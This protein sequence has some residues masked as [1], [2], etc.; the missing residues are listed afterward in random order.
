MFSLSRFLTIA[1]VVG[2]VASSANGAIL[3]QNGSSESTGA[4]RG[5]GLFQVSNWTN[6]SG[7]AIQASSAAAGFE[8]AAAG[9]ASGAR[10]LRLVYDNPDPSFT[11]FIVQNLGTMVAGE[12]YTITG[13][14]LGGRGVGLHFSL[15]AQL[16]SDR[17]L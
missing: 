10:Y 11:G 13:D 17:L 3:L 7:L 16:S 4:S 8:A 12:T 6:N 9:G 5:S 2:V 1:L 15:L 14:L